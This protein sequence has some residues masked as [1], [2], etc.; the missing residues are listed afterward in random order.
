MLAPPTTSPVNGMGMAITVTHDR[1]TEAT[2]QE[3]G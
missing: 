3:K 1:C 2:E